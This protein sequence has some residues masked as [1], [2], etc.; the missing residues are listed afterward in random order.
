MSFL[1]PKELASHGLCMVHEQALFQMSALTFQATLST[2]LELAVFIVVFEFSD[3]LS[4]A[5]G[6]QIPLVGLVFLAPFCNPEPNPVLREDGQCHGHIQNQLLNA[7]SELQ[8]LSFLFRT[9][10]LT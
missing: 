8:E 2:L 9:T 7:Q 10:C 5:A 1:F 4:Q 6:R 3:P